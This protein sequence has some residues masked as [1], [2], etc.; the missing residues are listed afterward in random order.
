[1][2]GFERADIEGLLATMEKN[3][4]GWAEAMA[5]VIMKNAERPELATELE[6]RFCATDPA[7]AHDFAT[8]TFLGDNRADLAAVTVPSLILQC[9]EDDIAPDAVGEYLRDHLP[10]STFH[11]LEATGHCPHLSHPAETT[12]AIRQYLAGGGA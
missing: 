1:M 9:S 10:G 8:A 6:A 12:A 3:Y 5:P 2:G 4:G 7:I 11:K